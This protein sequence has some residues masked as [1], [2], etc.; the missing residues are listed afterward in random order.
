MKKLIAFAVV[1]LL[2]VG[3]VKVV[4]G[5]SAEGQA[6]T[7]C[8]NLIEQCGGLAALG[9]EKFTAKDVD[10]CTH[11]FATK[12]K[13][14][15]GDQYQ[16]MVTCIADADTCGEAIGCLGGAF[17]NEIGKEMDGFGRGFDRMTK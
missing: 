8:E 13:D 17:A 12:G 5:Q 2:V 1:A 3:L 15:L 16:P 9:G 6:R 4:R 14:A 7:A 11:D 10:D